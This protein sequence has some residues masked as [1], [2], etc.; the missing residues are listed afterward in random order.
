MITN[1]MKNTNFTIALDR[2]AHQWAKTFA[3]QQT[4]VKKGRRVYLNTLAVCA[5]QRYLSC[6]CQLQ[7]SPGDAWEPNNQCIMDVAD[8]VVPGLGKIECRPVLFGETEMLVPPES[9]DDRIA[10]VAVQFNEDLSQVELLG[11]TTELS[12][13]SILID[14][15]ALIESLIDLVLPDETMTNLGEV[16]SGIFNCGWESINSLVTD[17]TQFAKQ[18]LALRNIAATLSNSPYESIRAFTAG[19]MMDLKVKLGNISL[20]LLIGLNKEPDGRIKVRVRLYSSG[21]AAQLPA[22][23]QLSLQDGTGQVKGQVQY[24]QPMNFIQL[25]YFRLESGTRFDIQVALADSKL[26]ESFIA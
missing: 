7:L 26:T 23:M 22:N 20:L 13:G 14:H 3:A 10:Y 18:E 5:V 12:S 1:F 17:E 11:C 9:I 6:I 4:T 8:L 19:K 25:N 21:N 2:D 16:L 15:L 24:A